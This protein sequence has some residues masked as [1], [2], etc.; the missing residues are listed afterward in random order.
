ME[1]FSIKTLAAIEGGKYLNVQ[2]MLDR[3]L[4][5][6]GL[7]LQDMLSSLLQGAIIE[8]AADSLISKSFGETWFNQQDGTPGLRIEKASTAISNLYVSRIYFKSHLVTSGLIITLSDGV[9]SES[10]PVNALA[11]EEVS[12][13]VNFLTTQRKIDIT[14][15]ST[16]APSDGVAPYTQNIGE[17]DCF[18]YRDCNYCCGHRYLK[19]HG[20]S[21]TSAETSS[22]YGIRADVLLVCDKSKMVC[23][24]VPQN[25]TLIL[26]MTQIEILKEW[27]A[28]ERF[29]FLAINSKEWAKEKIIELVDSIDNLWIG[30]GEGIK[31]LLI[32]TEKKCFNCTGYGYTELIP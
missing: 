16:D 9:N 18:D 23:L 19:I 7:K 8:Q 14:Y 3:K 31:N 21:F 12:I 26:Q 1:G 22:Y 32:S 30:N 25:K 6:V 15:S 24:I 13:E 27:I 29:N 28:T 20:L 4:Q 17:Y 11:D 5:V 2:T 10:F